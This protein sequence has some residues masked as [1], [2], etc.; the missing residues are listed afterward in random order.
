MNY[1]QSV[2]DHYHQTTLLH[3]QSSQTDASLQSGSIHSTL[4]T[5]QAYQPTKHAQLNN[6]TARGQRVLC[7]GGVKSPIYTRRSF[8]LTITARHATDK[9]RAYRNQEHQPRQIIHIYE[10]LR[11]KG[12]RNRKQAKARRER[13]PP[14]QSQKGEIFTLTQKSTAFRDLSLRTYFIFIEH[15]ALAFFM[16]PSRQNH[17]D[18]IKER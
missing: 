2:I 18:G 17:L 4:N 14:Q 11:Q 12:T 1:Q 9:N 8:T 13:K 6:A 10:W 16:Q 15:N 5:K 7:L 3:R